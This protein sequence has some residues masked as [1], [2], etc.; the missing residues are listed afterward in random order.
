MNGC[1]QNCDQGR[2]C[3]CAPAFQ[4]KLSDR[5]LRK[6]IH[7]DIW[8]MSTFLGGK[9][10]ETI[11]AASWNAWITKRWWF[12]WTHVVID[13]IFLLVEFKWNHCKRAWT[14]QRELYP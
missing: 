12:G 9:D 8:L 7:F 13:L 5:I 6:L 2:R 11:S 10:R 1:N 3:D 4:T 14:W